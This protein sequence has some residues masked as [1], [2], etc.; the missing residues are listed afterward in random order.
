MAGQS[1]I[2]P[3][4]PHVLKEEPDLPIGQLKFN[5]ERCTG[6]KEC[7]NA[8]A[9][10]H[11]KTKFFL[12]AFME[13]P[14]PFSRIWVVNHNGIPIPVTCRHCEEA[15]CIAVC[16]AEAIEKHGRQRPV[17]AN[18]NLCQGCKCCLFACPFGVMILDHAIAAPAKCDLC[19]ERLR[20]GRP[21]A[22][23]EACPTKAIEFISAKD[24]SDAARRITAAK[25]LLPEAGQKFGFIGENQ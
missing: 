12:T 2:Q 11:S 7:E 22:C 18:N 13:H 1:L 19:I 20:Q 8:C 14:R 4:S 24:S 6:C 10:E 3:I 9:T 16:E 17:I 5:L 21:P 25:H 23:V 15:P